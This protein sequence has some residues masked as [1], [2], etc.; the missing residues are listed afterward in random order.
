M[1]TRTKIYIKNAQVWADR[2]RKTMPIL[3]CVCLNG[4]IRSTDLDAWYEAKVEPDMPVGCYTKQDI[5]QL[6][7]GIEVK[8]VGIEEFP[9]LGYCRDQTYSER[10]ELPVVALRESLA[11]AIKHASTDII[12]E[13]IT[14]ACIQGSKIVAT[15][16]HTLYVDELGGY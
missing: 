3:E 12:R 14:T 5:A 15:S 7:A 11:K 9:D 16:G 10:V 1:N 6:D 13:N 4:S 2:R 8:P